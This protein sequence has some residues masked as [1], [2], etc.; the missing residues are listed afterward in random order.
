MGTGTVAIAVMD[1]ILKGNTFES[2]TS[3]NIIRK[4]NNQL[5]KQ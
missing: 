3:A 2:P 4:T 1:Q 5:A